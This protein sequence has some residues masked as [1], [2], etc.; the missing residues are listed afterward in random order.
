[1]G[2]IKATNVNATAGALFSLADIEQQ[3]RAILLRARAEADQ[4]LAEANRIA[5]GLRSNAASD[6]KAAGMTQGQKE[7]R[8]QAL[9]AAKAQALTEQKAK[10]T[11][12][13]TA[14]SN[15]A[16]RVESQIRSIEQAAHG[17]VV[18]LAIAIARRVTRT[19]AANDVAIAEANVRE[20]VR[21]AT[22]KAS[23]RI[24]IHPSQRMSLLELLPQLKMQWPTMQHAELVDDATLAVGGCRIAT[25]SGEIDADLNRQLDRIESELMPGGDVDGS[26]TA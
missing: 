23:V 26:S 12:S 18:K 4:I 11:E 1:M 21:L 10:L 14:F 2:L 20:A 17:E 13:I 19:L 5:D 24:A 22:S 16:T 8:E 15:A 7:G 3:A 6:G 9:A 25:L